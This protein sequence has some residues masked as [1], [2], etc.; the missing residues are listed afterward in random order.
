MLTRYGDRAQNRG[1][2]AVPG[3]LAIQYDQL[4]F[5]RRARICSWMAK[6]TS[7]TLSRD[8]VAG[9]NLTLGLGHRGTWRLTETEIEFEAVE[10]GEC[11]LDTFFL[12]FV[13]EM[14]VVLA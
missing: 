3:F 4:I 7:S 1:A 14:F 6:M 13:G 12:E 8:F 2:A 9:D 10:P 5:G 11:R